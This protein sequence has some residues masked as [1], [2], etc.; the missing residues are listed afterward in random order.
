VLTIPTVRARKPRAN[1][2]RIVVAALVVIGLVLG[3]VT[4]V[5]GPAAL[6]RPAHQ[7]TLEADAPDTGSDTADAAD[8]LPPATQR[9]ASADRPVPVEPDPSDDPSE[10]LDEVAVGIDAD[11]PADVLE[12]I[13]NE[14]GSEPEPEPEPTTDGPEPDATAPAAPGVVHLTFDDGP[15]PAHTP[16]VLD[17]LARHDAKATFFVLGSLAEAHP[18]LV[19]RIAA[20]GHTL[21]NHSWSHQDLAQMNQQQFNESVGRTQAALGE[22]ATSCLRPPYGSMNANTRAWAAELG[23]DVVLWDTDTLDWQK[24]GVDTI[25]DTIVRGATGGP[26][27]LLH[28]GG[29]DRTQSVQALDQALGE[30]SGHGFSFE[31]ICS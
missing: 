18:Q 11:Q 23:L 13:A 28:D 20:E 7:P 27:I 3:A 9:D 26:N 31:P 25:A 17:V 4:L 24:P 22:H 21:A 15:H 5:G 19:E 6:A 10:L 30:L 12:G 14:I 29:G 1:R 2:G 16:A 8:P